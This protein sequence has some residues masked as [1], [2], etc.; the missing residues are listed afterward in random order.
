MVNTFMHSKTVRPLKSSGNLC[1][2]QVQADIFGE[3]AINRIFIIRELDHFSFP[4]RHLKY[5]HEKTEEI[6][7]AE[8][9][10]HVDYQV[11]LATKKYK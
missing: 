6:R 9:E 5:N 10:I 11:R 8:V 3:D 4:V 7:M 2:F 1:R